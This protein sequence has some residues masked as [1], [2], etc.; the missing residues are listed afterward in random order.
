MEIIET[1]KISWY[2]GRPAPGKFKCMV[3][4]KSEA[5]IKIKL[6]EGIA[7]INIIICQGCLDLGAD[8]IGPVIFK[9]LNL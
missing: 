5:T 9:S 3:C 4:Q 2:M 8:Y 1:K 7:K 6:K